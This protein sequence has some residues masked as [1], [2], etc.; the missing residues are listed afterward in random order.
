MQ[1]GRLLQQ[2]AMTG[3]EEGDPRTKSSLAKFDKVRA[4]LG[5]L[6]PSAASVCRHCGGLAGLGVTGTEKQITSCTELGTKFW[7][8]ELRV[9]DSHFYSDVIL[10]KTKHKK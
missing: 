10:L 1:V 7:V 2:L 5:G 3:A 9:R 4:K 8:L 6:S